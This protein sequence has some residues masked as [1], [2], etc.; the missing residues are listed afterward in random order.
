MFFGQPTF[1]LALYLH[2]TTLAFVGLF[3]AASSGEVLF[4]REEADILMHR[5]V[6]SRDLLRAKASMLIQLSLW[7]AG[8]FNIPGLVVGVLARDGSWGFPPAHLLSTALESLFCVGGVVLLY[9]FCLSRFGRER[10]DGLMTTAQVLV[11]IAAIAGGQIVPQLLN[12]FGGRLEVSSSSWWLILLPPAWFAGLDDALAG[13]HAPGS[14]GLAA[15]AL[16]STAG[17]LWAGLGRLSRDYEAGLQSLQEGQGVK[18]PSRAGGRSWLETLAT[19]PP[20]RWWLRNP[21]T[22]ST[23]LLIGA[24]LTRDRDV[25]LRVYPSLAPMLVMPVGYPAAS[26]RVPDLTRKPLS[27]IAVWK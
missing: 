26:A 4:N 24:Y 22:R 12:R 11:A 25:K 19:L 16:V 15:L 18:A 23:F 7:L 5:P 14:W 2:A 21:L 27:D 17:L 10:L 3:V 8:A 20:F 13:S 6:A 1:A 9:Q